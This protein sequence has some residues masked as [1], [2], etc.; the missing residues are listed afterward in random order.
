M[1]NDAVKVVALQDIA[2][3]RL[4]Y[5]FRAAVTNAP[6]GDVAVVQIKNVHP[7]RGIDWS[8]LANTSLTGRKKPDW[9]QPGDVLFAARGSRNIAVCV[10]EVPG[11]AVCAPQ[12]YLVRIRDSAVLPEYLAWY[13]NEAPAQRYLAQSAEGTLVTSIRRAVLEALPVPVPG[14][15]RQQI[16]A[17]LATAAR[18]EKLLTEQLIRNREQQLRLVAHGLIQQVLSGEEPL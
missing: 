6:D 10:G 14:V 1:K 12:F 18:H 3:T 4:G 5:S 8:A 15:E 16:I 2:E 13:I 11:K 7:Q 9:L 17:H